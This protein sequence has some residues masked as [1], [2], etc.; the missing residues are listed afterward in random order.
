MDTDGYLTEMKSAVTSMS[1]TMRFGEVCASLHPSEFWH[2]IFRGRGRSGGL[3][4]L[5][6]RAANPGRGFSALKYKAS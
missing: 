1:W 5:G 2:R 3:S 6:R 4:I